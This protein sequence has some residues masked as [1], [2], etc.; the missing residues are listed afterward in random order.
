MAND[1]L[2]KH[3]MPGIASHDPL[4]SESDYLRDAA[5]LIQQMVEEIAPLAKLNST[6]AITLE[7]LR[8]DVEALIPVVDFIPTVSENSPCLN[9]LKQLAR[10]RIARLAA[11]LE[12]IVNLA[13]SPLPDIPVGERLIS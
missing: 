3:V 2:S 10:T 7:D 6:M 1:I 5:T 9:E 4:Q 12:E 11:K 8:R 13:E